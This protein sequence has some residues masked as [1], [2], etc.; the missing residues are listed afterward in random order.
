MAAVSGS[1]TQCFLAKIRAGVG[2]WFFEVATYRWQ[3][4]VGPGRDYQLG[5]RAESECE[6]WVATDPIRVLANDLPA[7]ER[8]RIETEVK[9]EI[10][11]AFAFAEASDFPAPTELMSDIFKEDSHALATCQG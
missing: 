10:A 3:E 6:P 4:H 7:D 5:Y 9:E 2:P 11:S 1:G 8:Q